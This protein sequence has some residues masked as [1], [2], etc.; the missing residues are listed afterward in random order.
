MGDTGPEIEAES[1]DEHEHEHEAEALR[2]K[3]AARDPSLITRT[4]LRTITRT[5]LMLIKIVKIA[6]KAKSAL[7]KLK[8]TPRCEKIKIDDS[9]LG[10]KRQK[11]RIDDSD[12]DEAFGT[13]EKHP[14]S[15]GGPSMG[16]IGPYGS[17]KYLKFLQDEDKR[18]RSRGA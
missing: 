11:I 12:L 17:L 8:K 3:V 14:S 6:E 10:L 2:K 16:G 1:H 4:R 18:R 5:P 9:D 15:G 7:G 13:S